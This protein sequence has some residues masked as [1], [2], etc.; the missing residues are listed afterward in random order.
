MPKKLL[1]I[2]YYWP[3]SA[4]GGV[5]RWLKFVKYLSEFGWEPIVFTPENPDFSIQDPSLESDVPNSVEVIRFPIW[6]LSRLTGSNKVQQGVVKKG[7]EVSLIT[8]AMIWARGNLIIPDPKRFWVKPSVQFLSDYLDRN[9]VDALVTTGP[10]HS[11]HLIGRKLNEKCQVPWL[12]DFRDP[13]SDWDILDDLKTGEWARSIH[14]KLEMN[15]MK[16]A[17]R[18]LACT[19]AMERLFQEKSDRIQTA[20]VTNGVDESDFTDYIRE[21]ASQEYFTLSHMGLLNDMRNPSALWKVLEQ[22]C[23]ELDGFAKSLRIFLSGMISQDVLESLQKSGLSKNLQYEKYLSHQEV[24]Q[25]YSQSSVLLLLMNRSDNADW[26]IPG[27][28]FEYFFAEREVLAFGSKVSDVNTI[29]NE[30]NLGAVVDYDDVVTIKERI[31]Q[32]YQRFQ[33]GMYHVPVKNMENYTRRKLTGQLAK[34]LNE[35]TESKS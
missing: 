24:V 18:V 3:P 29:L 33:S 1:V 17:D 30:A 13:W 27:K 11:M 32:A 28:L 19:P 22:L 2:T 5:Q 9:P 12:A 31:K 10:P 16:S 20:M 35:M 25:Q 26:L 23:E 15:V 8:K 34:V 14:R 7:D 21:P 6:E 4:G